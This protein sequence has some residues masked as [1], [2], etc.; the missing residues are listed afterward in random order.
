[1]PLTEAVTTSHYVGRTFIQPGQ[2]NRTALLT[3]STISLQMKYIGKKVIFVDDSAVRLTT[4][5]A[6]VQELR[7]AGA[8]GVYMGIAS[9]PVVNQC[10]MGIDMREKKYLPAAKFQNLP[11]SEIEKNIAKYINADGVVYLPIEETTKAMGGTPQDFYHYPF[12]GPHPLRDKQHHFKKRNAKIIGL[13]KMCI[14]ASKVSK[15]SNLENIINHIENGTIQAAIINVLS[16]SEDSYSLVRA[17]KHK[18]PTT[19]IPYKG[20]LSDEVARKKF[21]KKLISFIS[22]L[23][24]NVILLSGWDFIL[25]DYFLKKMQ[26]LQIPVINH[27]PALLTNNASLTVTTSKGKFP[28]IRGN[29]KFEASFISDSEISGLSVHQVIPGKCMT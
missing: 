9:P 22:L 7:K 23:N 28:V 5:K 24:P 25:S 1:M 20:K 3:E 26:G 6:L 27:H 21:E 11:I 18:I 17:R 10:D 4:S 19:V 14:F 13:P 29:N 16:N 12:G 8:K 2:K 15:G